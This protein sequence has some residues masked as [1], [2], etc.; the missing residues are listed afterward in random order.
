MTDY[1]HDMKIAQEYAINNRE[2]MME[3]LLDGLGIM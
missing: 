2:A 3:V 1:L